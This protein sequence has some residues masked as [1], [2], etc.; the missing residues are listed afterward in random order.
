MQQNIEVTLRFS[1]WDI[2]I[3]HTKVYEFGKFSLF[4]LKAI[5]SGCSIEDISEITLISNELINKYL[6]YV[7]KNGYLNENNE[8]TD[9]GKDIVELANLVDSIDKKFKIFLDCY[10][11]DPEIKPIF[12]YAIINKHSKNINLITPTLSLFKISKFVKDKI[13]K[14][15]I[16]SYLKIKSPEIKLSLEREKENISID[17][18]FEG[19]FDVTLKIDANLFF[20]CLSYYPKG[21]NIIVGV[22]VLV[23]EEKYELNE[24]AN[25]KMR[26]KFQDWLESNQKSFRKN[27]LELITGKIVEEEFEF[28]S[29]EKVTKLEPVVNKNELSPPNYNVKIP[30]EFTWYIDIKRVQSYEYIKGYLD[31]NKFFQIIIDIT[32]DCCESH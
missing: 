14:N 17:L 6:E 21:R 31:V 27:I 7:R 22:P 1:Q 9:K 16:I 25:K 11:E 3:G 30:E 26:K 8:I 19:F 23:F 32:K 13:F 24:S 18:D 20:D 12:N 2:N 5:D 4:C 10:I 29:D 28:V 15:K